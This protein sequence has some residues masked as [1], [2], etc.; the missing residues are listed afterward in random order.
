MVVFPGRVHLGIAQIRAAAL[1]I[2]HHLADH[3]SFL[4]LVGQA[5]PLCDI[6]RREAVGVVGAGHKDCVILASLYMVA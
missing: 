6:E 5:A 1:R 3:E 2:A 4:Q